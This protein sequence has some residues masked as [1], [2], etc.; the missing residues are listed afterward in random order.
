MPHP[1]RH[2]ENVHGCQ[3]GYPLFEGLFQ[4]N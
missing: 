3:D 1:E 2:T 4:S